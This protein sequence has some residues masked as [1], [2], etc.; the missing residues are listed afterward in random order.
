MSLARQAGQR[1][2]G[3][4]VPRGRGERHRDCAGLGC[5]RPRGLAAAGPHRGAA[6][7]SPTSAARSMAGR[8]RRTSASSAF[9]GNRRP[10]RPSDHRRRAAPHLRAAR[11][12]E[13]LADLPDPPAGRGR[14]AADAGRPQAAALP[15]R[16]PTMRPSGVCRRCSRRAARRRPR[17]R[18][19]SPPGAR[20][21]ARAPA[22]PACRRPGAHR[23]R[24]PA[25]APEHLYEACS[26]SCCGSSSSSTP[27]TATSSHRA[28]TP[29]RAA[30]YDAG[31][32]RARAPCASCST[33][34]AH[35]PDTMDERRGGWGRLLA[36]FRLVHHG[37][38]TRLDP[39]P[40]RQA[41]RPRGLPVPARPG[42]ARRARPR[43]R[44]CP[45][46]ASLR[47]LD[48]C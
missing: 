44:P 13:R 36:L 37:D 16:L 22:R 47:V 24:S 12:D 27:R 40:R 15:F 4:T 29:R 19:G 25:H 3:G 46:A 26:P 35:H 11:R 10:A 32:R 21:A 39:R 28:P 20:R 38:G 41:V 30:F 34:R 33:T 14:R 5:H 7:S 43:P 42:R 9:C 2:P 6:A 1:S 31:L 17:S 18:R 45:T 48:G 23:A 8:R